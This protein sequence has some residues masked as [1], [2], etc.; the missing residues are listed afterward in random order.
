MGYIEG[1][2]RNQMMLF[3]DVVD[4]YIED[5]NPVR[6]I[7]AFVDSLDL[8]KFGFTHAE[9]EDTGRPPYNPSDLLKLYI[10]GYLNRIRSSRGLE[11]ETRRN[12]E[13]MW[14][15]RKLTPD[16]KTIA[17][18]RRDNKK[19]IKKKVCRQ[20]ILLCKRLNLLSGELVAIDGS[21]FKAVNSKKRNFNKKKLEKK[22]R[23]IDE[24]IEAYISDLD[25]NDRGEGSF[26]SVNG[27]REKVKMRQSDRAYIWDNKE[28]FQSRIFSNEGEGECISRDG[29]NSTCL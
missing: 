6:F 21:K 14:L 25:E 11:K 22:I 10:Y 5:N 18:F 28:E 19:A 17:D 4:D 24:K 15:L 13:L 20:F 2:A 8:V 3:P 29:F 7:D 1:V 9:T 23:E 26:S 12:I 27:E 16:F